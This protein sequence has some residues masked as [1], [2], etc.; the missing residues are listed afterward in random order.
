MPRAA[1]QLKD[2]LQGIEDALAEFEKQRKNVLRIGKRLRKSVDS[3]SDADIRREI[4]AE[5]EEL[6]ELLDQVFLA[7]RIRW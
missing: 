2:I 1:E 7:D 5:L 6:C 4:E 3:I